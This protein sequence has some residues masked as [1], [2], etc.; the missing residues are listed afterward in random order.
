MCQLQSRVTILQQYH[1]STGK[2]VATTLARRAAIRLCLAPGLLSVR[3]VVLDTSTASLTLMLWLLRQPRPASGASLHSLDGE[4]AGR[5]E[6]H[7]DENGFYV[8]T[9]RGIDF[10]SQWP[11]TI[12]RRIDDR[13]AF[14]PVMSPRSRKSEWV[15]RDPLCPREQKADSAA[16]T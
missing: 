12:A 15:T 3:P 7:L 5:L 1:Y 11:D 13:L 8:W 2:T 9:D 6:Q 16:A 10:G 4:Y 14:I